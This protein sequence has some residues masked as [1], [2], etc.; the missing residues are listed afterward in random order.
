[1][2]AGAMQHITDAN[3]RRLQALQDAAG[4]AFTAH[5]TRHKAEIARQHSYFQ[6]KFSILEKNIRE[7]PDAATST[8]P[9]EPVPPP[10]DYPGDPASADALLKRRAQWAERRRL[11]KLRRRRTT[12]RDKSP[13]VQ[14][15]PKELPT[16][17]MKKLSTSPQQAQTPNAAEE[18]KVLKEIEKFEKMRRQ[19]KPEPAPT[20]PP[21]PDPP[22]AATP[23]SPP[24]E[25][26][27]KS[28]GFSFRKIFD[29]SPQFRDIGNE[30]NEA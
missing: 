25:E 1:M 7:I 10:A 16:D 6:Q 9:E 14:P 12:P 15:Q 17:T 5:V 18:L 29:L 8:S 22:M 20:L 26:K 23:P 13:A 21:E 2:D 28:G 4:K 19:L 27:R 24:A 11:R 30:D 3:V